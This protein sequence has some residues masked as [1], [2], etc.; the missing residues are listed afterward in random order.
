MLVQVCPAL[1]D[2]TVFLVLFAGALWRRRAGI[3]QFPMCLD[4]WHWALSYMV[5]S[6]LV[7]LV[8]TRR[9][10]RGFLLVSVMGNLP[11]WE[12]SACC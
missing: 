2:W 9:N 1:M 7:G 12:S 3:K 10:A 8:L 5:T 6:L 11:Q 4:R